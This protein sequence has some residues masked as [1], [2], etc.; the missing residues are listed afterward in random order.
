M[1]SY[2]VNIAEKVN[3]FKKQW[4]KTISII[5][6]LNYVC[7][8]S[9]IFIGSPDTGYQLIY[10]HYQIWSMNASANKEILIKF[11]LSQPTAIE[12]RLLA[13]LT[14]RN[15]GTG[16]K[17]KWNNTLL[18]SE[19]FGTTKASVTI[20]IKKVFSQPREKFPCCWCSTSSETGF[21]V[22]KKTVV[23]RRWGR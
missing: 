2:M 10:L 13:E 1:Y 14:S 22:S 18:C 6:K 12:N 7:Q 20:V 15:T 17:Y 9:S 11:F 4:G 21:L 23:L 19:C 8:I 16:S 3:L 5:Y